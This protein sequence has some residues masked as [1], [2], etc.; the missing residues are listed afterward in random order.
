VKLRIHPFDRGQL[1]LLLIMI[2][3]FALTLI[4]Y[5]LENPFLNGILR[6]GTAGLLF[7]YLLYAFKV[8]EDM[9]EML[10]RSLGRFG[11]RLK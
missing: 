8:S 3:M 2:P 1:R 6:T 5:R 10:K 7:V 9:N 11:I 4:P